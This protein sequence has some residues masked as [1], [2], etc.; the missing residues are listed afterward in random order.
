MRESHLLRLKWEHEKQEKKKLE[1]KLE[2]HT[3]KVMKHDCTLKHA[4]MLDV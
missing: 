2:A 4:H 3:N 1:E